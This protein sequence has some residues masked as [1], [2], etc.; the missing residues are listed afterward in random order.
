MQYPPS[1]PPAKPGNGLGVAALIVG[2]VAL[3]GAFIPLINFVSGFLAV[4]GIILG[5]IAVVRKNKPKKLAIAGLIVSVVALILSVV[6][7]FAYTAG[8]VAAVEDSTPQTSEQKE[9]EEAAVGPR[10][11]VATDASAEVGTRENPAPIGTTVEITDAGTPEYE[12]TL[13]APILDATAAVAEA[14]QFN[15][16]APEGFQYA[17]LP[18]TVTYVGTD[19]GTPWI[20]LNLAFVSAA[21]TTHDEA[22]S[23]V[24]AP[25]PTFMEINELYPGAS[26]TGNIVVAIPTADAA[27]GAW[28]VEAL[29]WG[30]SFFFAAQ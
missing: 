6:L 22:D 16:P 4:V 20:D 30:D 9:E 3:I 14:N 12:V 19:T 27:N 26:G 18:V 25:A 7:A 23:L 5:I 17:V 24:V 1:A 8:F 13:G 15:E 28:T 2:I 29:F 11:D 10:D 21:G